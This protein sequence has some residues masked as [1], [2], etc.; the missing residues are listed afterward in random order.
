MN[1]SMPLEL[2]KLMAIVIVRDRYKEPVYQRLAPLFDSLMGVITY[3]NFESNSPNFV[4]DLTY[5]HTRA[6]EFGLNNK[7]PFVVL[8]EDA[9]TTQHY[10]VF[11]PNLPGV[12]KLDLNE[13]QPYVCPRVWAEEVIKDSW[14]RVY[15]QYSTGAYLVNNIKQ[16]MVLLEEFKNCPQEPAD[17][18]FIS[19]M[20]E[21]N[22]YCPE[23][24]YFYHGPSSNPKSKRTLTTVSKIEKEWERQVTRLVNQEGTNNEP[25]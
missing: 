4:K 21:L 1:E 8:E 17:S 2:N 10:S 24:P 19:K 20:K 25:S 23:L 15:S 11:V 5:N 7:K 14:Y 16:G 6:L 12:I 13:H 22:F 3:N 18:I 9:F